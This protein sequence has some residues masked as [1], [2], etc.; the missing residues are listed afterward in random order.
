MTHSQPDPP[1]A[2]PSLIFRLLGW[3][4]STSILASIA[5]PIFIISAVFS[6]G[7]LEKEKT[8]IVTHGASG[9][10]I[11]ER[12]EQEGALY[13]PLLFRIAARLTGALKAGEY[14]LPPKASAFDIATILHEGRSIARMFTVPEGL[15]SAEI[16]SLLNN[17]PALTGTI[18]DIP[19]EGSL[20]PET[21][22][23]TYGDS[24]S[25]LVL[26]M[27]KALSDKINAAWETRAPGLPLKS[28]EEAL[29][30]ASIV[31]K[32]TGVAEERA[33][34]AG[35]FHN[36][37]R[38]RMRLQSDPTVIYALTEGKA[39]LNRSLTYADLAFASPINTYASDGLP[40]KP[41]CNPGSA[42]IDATLKPEETAFFYFVADGQGGHA[43]AAT[44]EEHNKNV[45]NWRRIKDRTI[46]R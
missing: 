5:A 39:P 37:L 6:E 1:L 25:G 12:L 9:A 26:R 24:R 36:R 8:I 45:A 18:E 7:P 32:E 22:R 34:V 20:L 11:G 16:V 17:T 43:F 42:A 46:S 35:V 29:V 10:A 33:R 13:T 23:Y 41:I 40:P 14:T 30:L 19:Q 2:P 31:E 3:V 28:V 15:T 4:L 27:Q 21:Y 38:K 44:L